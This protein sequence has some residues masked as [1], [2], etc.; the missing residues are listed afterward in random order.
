MGGGVALIRCISAVEKVKVSPEEQ[1]G[2]DIIRRSLEEPA[3]WIAQN[4]GYEAAVIADELKKGSGAHGFNAETGKF[5]DLLKA[6]IIDP[7]KVTRSA[8]QNAASVASLLLTTEAM[9]ADAKSDD[10]GGPSMPP[11]GMGGM[12]GMM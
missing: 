11:G 2:V 12:G 7:T 9:I 5:E 8:L 4:G 6:G 3:R 1:F 10:K